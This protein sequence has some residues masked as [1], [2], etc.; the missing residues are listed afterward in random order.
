[1]KADLGIKTHILKD[2][3]TRSLPRQVEVR[4]HADPLRL[5]RR[6][7]FNEATI[8][9][10][11]V[12]SMSAASP[13]YMSKRYVH[14]PNLRHPLRDDVQ[15]ALHRKATEEPDLVPRIVRETVEQA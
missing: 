7:W 14:N 2:L 3:H 11:G 15:H 10:A 12:D 8:L 1:M 4:D 13:W 9:R 5:A 6:K